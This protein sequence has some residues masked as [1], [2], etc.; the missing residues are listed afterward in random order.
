[1]DAVV[2][3]VVGPFPF[4][5]RGQRSLAVQRDAVILGRYQP[6]QGMAGVRARVIVGL[7]LDRDVVAVMLVGLESVLE[8]R[9]LAGRGTPNPPGN[10]GNDH[11][12]SASRP[13][14]PLRDLASWGSVLGCRRSP[15][16]AIDRAALPILQH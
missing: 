8:L 11:E 1:M 14:G 15:R 10:Q 7:D 9:G 3:Q 6:K 5:L 2:G 12:Q 13:H 4:Y 16:P